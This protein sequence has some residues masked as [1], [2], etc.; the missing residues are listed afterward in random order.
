MSTTHVYRYTTVHTTH[1][2]GRVY[3]PHTGAIYGLCIRRIHGSC[4]QPYTPPCLPPV[5]LDMFAAHVH[6][7]AVFTTC[8]YARLHGQWPCAGRVHGCLYGHVPTVST[9][10]YVPY[11]CPWTHMSMDMAV[12]TTV[13]TGRILRCARRI[14]PPRTCTD[15][16]HTAISSW[17]VYGSFTRPWTRSGT[18]PCAPP[19]YRPCTGLVHGRVQYMAPVHVHVPLRVHGQHGYCH[20]YSTNNDKKYN[21][22]DQNVHGPM[23]N[24]M[25][26]LRI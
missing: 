19:Y 2:H 5:Y 18:R 26:A 1:V 4:T 25:A 7:P 17:A 9:S 21:N 24:V 16:V 13:Y 15:R 8:A 3:G 23:P 11:T 10:V 20:F 6:R 14:R 12:Y 22:N